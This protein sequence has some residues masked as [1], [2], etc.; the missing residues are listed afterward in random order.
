MTKLKSAKAG[1]VGEVR[2]LQLRGRISDESAGVDLIDAVS[3]RAIAKRNGVSV[4]LPVTVFDS[5]TGVVDVAL[6]ALPADWLPKGPSI[7]KWQFEVEVTYT[8]GSILTWPNEGYDEIEVYRDL[9]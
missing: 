7:G 8:N 3:V 1:D 4:V 2:R 9:D 6:G 5:A